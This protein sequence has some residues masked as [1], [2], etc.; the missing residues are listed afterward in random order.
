MLVEGEGSSLYWYILGFL[1]CLF[2]QWSMLVVVVVVV[3][4]VL[5]EPVL[6]VVLSSIFTSRSL[7]IRAR[8]VVVVMVGV[9]VVVVVHDH[10]GSHGCHRRTVLLILAFLSTLIVKAA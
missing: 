10:T 8:L 2:I 1:S 4:P 3:E 6:V 9:V 7:Y 5:L